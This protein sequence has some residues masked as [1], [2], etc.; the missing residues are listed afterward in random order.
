[1]TPCCRR[2]TRA[3]ATPTSAC[4]VAS[5]T[6]FVL[7]SLCSCGAAEKFVDINPEDVKHYYPGV[8]YKPGF[9]YKLDP[10]AEPI[11]VLMRHNS[12][13]YYTMEMGVTGD[14][15]KDG[16]VLTNGWNTCQLRL[17]VEETRNGL[18]TWTV[19][20][21]SG[22]EGFQQLTRTEVSYYY[23]Q[24]I[25]GDPAPVELQWNDET[26]VAVVKKCIV[27]TDSRADDGIYN[28]T[29]APSGNPGFYVKWSA[30]MTTFVR[31]ESQTPVPTVP[32]EQPITA[33][34]TPKATGPVDTDAPSHA[35]TTA[36]H[37]NTTASWN[38]T[39]CNCRCSAAAVDRQLG[40]IV[41]AVIAM[42][43][44]SIVFLRA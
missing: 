43:F 11:T 13:V 15:D 39:Q 4:F 21:K 19:D 28:L 44:Y 40:S 20:E 29:F 9:Y 5:W 1:M 37:A 17:V 10:S 41:A 7:V 23:L 24:L 25:K 26:K 36:S 33:T 31:L 12:S 6:I 34:T 30:K 35:T 42:Q 38:D 27:Q 14:E 32:S 3:I 8:T 16:L 18:R 22:S 2:A